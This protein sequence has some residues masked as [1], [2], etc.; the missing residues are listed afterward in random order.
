VAS[1]VFGAEG[2][3]FV[4]YLCKGDFGYG[5]ALASIWRQGG[6]VLVEDDIAPWPGAIDQLLACPHSWCAFDYALGRGILM[7]SC[8]HPGLGLVKVDTQVTERDPDAGEPWRSI[9][10]QQLDKPVNE[11]IAR[12]A[13]RR[14][15]H[16]HRP[17]VAHVQHLRGA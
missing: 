6:F 10:W 12:L 4:S 3:S 1:R 2:L 9:H 13:H 14:K 5:E 7:S 11:T 17:G 15:A 8:S 16:M